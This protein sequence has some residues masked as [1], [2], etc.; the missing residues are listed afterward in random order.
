MHRNVRIFI[1][2]NVWQTDEKIRQKRSAFA[3]NTAPNY[4]LSRVV[5]ASPLI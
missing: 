5:V 4:T 1:I 2:N 3:G